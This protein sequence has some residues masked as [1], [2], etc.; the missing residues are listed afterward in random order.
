MTKIMLKK[1][2]PYFKPEIA[3]LLA[4]FIVFYGLVHFRAAQLNDALQQE[5]L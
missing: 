3:G 5:E 2:G 1:F 4:G